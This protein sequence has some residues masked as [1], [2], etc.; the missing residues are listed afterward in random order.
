MLL[1][2]ILSAIL[3]EGDGTLDKSSLVN[4]DSKKEFK[5]SAHLDHQW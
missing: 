3:K 5:V 1:L 4:V 2:E